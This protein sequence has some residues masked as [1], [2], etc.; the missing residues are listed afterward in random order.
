MAKR[1]PLR[2]DLEHVIDILRTNSM[3]RTVQ[4][5]SEEKGFPITHHQVRSLLRKNHIY[6]HR[7]A[8][9]RSKVFTQHEP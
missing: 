5:L 4:I 6:I 1:E 9:E 2:N 8:E 7:N 3:K